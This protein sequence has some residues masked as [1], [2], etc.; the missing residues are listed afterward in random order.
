MFFSMVVLP[1]KSSATRAVKKLSHSQPAR[2]RHEDVHGVLSEGLA[3]GLEDAV[4]AGVAA[5]E[6]G[7]VDLGIGVFPQVEAL[8]PA[9]AG[10][11]VELEI[12]HGIGLERLQMVR[13][14]LQFVADGVDAAEPLEIDVVLGQDLIECD[15]ERGRPGAADL[16]PDETR[17][18]RAEVNDGKRV[19]AQRD[20]LVRLIGLLGL[21]GERRSD[22][23]QLGR[24]DDLEFAFA[25]PLELRPDIDERAVFPEPFHRHILFER[26]L[27]EDAARLALQESRV[28]HPADQES[29]GRLN[30]TS[31]G[32]G[33][34]AV[35]PAV[36]AGAHAIV[37]D[38]GSLKAVALHLL[39]PMGQDRGLETGARA[40]GGGQHF[41]I[42]DDL[43]LEEGGLVQEV[44]AVGVVAGDLD[45]KD[46]AST[47]RLERP[48]VNAA[49]PV[50]AASGTV[51]D[52]SPVEVDAVE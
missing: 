5:R 43:G 52:E 36:V 46:V 48:F 26:A 19:L 45:G 1:H 28:G 29:A 14:R 27:C 3:G 34:G 17:E 21:A 24:G 16:C 11:Y 50:R 6:P 47:C 12:P 30:R 8:H 37:L 10:Q 9:V 44:V 15:V 25:I 4:Q 38:E 42:G 20:G 39:H 51:T 2:S 31:G 40:G 23:L 13:S 33:C 7:L 35:P 32:L 41:R 49:V 18:V 22:L